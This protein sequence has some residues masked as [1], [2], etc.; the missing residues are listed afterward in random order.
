M[1]A[2]PEVE[3]QVRDFYDE[4]GWQTDTA[5]QTADAQLWEFAREVPGSDI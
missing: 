1:L 4:R 2:V 3:D 5:G